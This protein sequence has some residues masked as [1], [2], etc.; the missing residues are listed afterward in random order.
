MSIQWKKLVV[1]ILLPL[2]VG[3]FSAFL[4]MGGM[5]AFDEQLNKPPLTPP[6][7]VFFVVW[8]V[9]YILMGISS[10]I[11]L[12]SE[13]DG[14]KRPAL[15]VYLVQLIFNFLWPL[16]FFGTENYIAAFLVL[17]VLWILI[18][19]TFRMFYSMK[20]SAGYLIIPYLIWVAFAG[21]LNIGVFLLN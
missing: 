16:V 14:R 10:Y 13:F 11:I 17:I 18:Y 6:G 7:W 12:T 3:G 21:Y 8:T 20:K 19:I 4:T 2:A 9:L 15:F 1:C 5:A